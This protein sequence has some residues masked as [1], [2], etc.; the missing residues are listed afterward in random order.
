MK[1]QERNRQE[2]K[3][4]APLVDAIL[5]EHIDFLDTKIKELRKAIY[6]LIRQ[7]PQLKHQMALLVSIPGI[8]DITAIRLL[9]EIR[10]FRDF[11]NAR[12]AYAG[13]NPSSSNLVPRSIARA[14]YPKQEAVRCGI[15]S[16][17]LLLWL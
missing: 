4:S 15:H 17:F 16:I 5:R 12:P 10:D 11:D 7:D 2:F 3:S 14:G 6:Q 1:Q 8:G 9:A 13:L